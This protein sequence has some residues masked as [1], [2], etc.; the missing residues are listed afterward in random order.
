MVEVLQVTATAPVLLYCIFCCQS[1]LTFDD[2]TSTDILKLTPSSDDTGEGRIAT[3]YQQ[4]TP[5]SSLISQHLVKQPGKNSSL[6]TRTGLLY[7]S[8]LVKQVNSHIAAPTS[9]LPV[10]SLTCTTV[11][12]GQHAMR[13]YAAADYAVQHV[14]ADAAAR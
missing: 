9:K 7:M 12:D 5:L 4:S 8:E 3:N 6:E 13:C 2:E 10:A 1:I 14:P 11:V